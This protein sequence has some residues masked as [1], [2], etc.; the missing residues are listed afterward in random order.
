MTRGRRYAALAIAIALAAIAGRAPVFAADPAFDPATGYRIAQ[1][2]APTPE[3]VPGG[4]R[5]TLE[6]LQALA[7]RGAVRSEERR[8]GKECWYRC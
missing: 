2:R 6:E 5:V 7:G 3:T 1:Y 4:T 8:V